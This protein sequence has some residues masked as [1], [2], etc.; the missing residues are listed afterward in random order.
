MPLDYIIRWAYGLSAPF[1]KGLPDWTSDNAHR[2]VIEARAPAALNESTCK[3]MMQSLLASRFKMGTH[4]ERREMRAYA[5]TVSK[6]GLRMREARDANDTAVV[7]GAVFWS[8]SGSRAEGV[9]MARFA[10]GLSGLS[11]IGAP[12][13]DRTGLKGTYAFSLNFTVREDDG[14]PAISTA[15]QEQLGLKLELIKAP[16][17]V[18]VVDHIEK[19]TAN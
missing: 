5:L 16:I 2:Y 15:L 18:L 19:P 3:A 14:L 13:V 6:K 10:T 17:E 11:A 12:V 9:T 1:V 7:N 4:R 8:A